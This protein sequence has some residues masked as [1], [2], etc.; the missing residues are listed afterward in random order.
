MADYLNNKSTDSGSSLRLS[1]SEGAKRCGS[2]KRIWF[3]AMFR[4]LL[5]YELK[6]HHT[7]KVSVSQNNKLFTDP[8]ELDNYFS[9]NLVLSLSTFES[10]YFLAP[11][12]HRTISKMYLQGMGISEIGKQCKH[13][14]KEV[15]AILHNMLG[16]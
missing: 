13:S 1:Q 15:I 5:A 4:N 10:N 9:S 8:I 16:I 12:S 11:D 7:K 2:S 3:V 14:T 6:H